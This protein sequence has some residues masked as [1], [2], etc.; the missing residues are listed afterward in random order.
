MKKL[1]NFLLFCL[2]AVVF[3]TNFPL[4]RLGET[5]AMHLEI[6]LPEIWLV[7]FFFTNLANLKSLIKFFP[8]KKLAIISLFPLYASLSII[9]SANRPRAILTA[10]LIW[11]IIFAILNILYL[12][13][14]A[15][16][17]LKQKLTQ[18][19]LATS[20]I[21]SIFCWLQC[22]LDL[23][24]V[25][26]NNSLMCAGCTYS[27]F[28]FPHPNGFAIEPQFMGGLLIAPAIFSFYLAFSKK[29][30]WHYYALAAFFSA[31]LFL[32]F[33]RGAIYAFI[34]GVVIFTTIT[35]MKN[36]RALLTL[37]LVVGAFF[38]TLAAQGIMAAV[39]P[40]SDNF[41]SGVTKSLHHLTLGHLDLRPETETVQ[42]EPTSESTETDSQTDDEAVQEAATEESE[43]IT[44]TYDGYVSESTDVRVNFTN[45]ALEAAVKS[46]ENLIFGTGLG[47]AG[48]ILNCEFPDAVGTPKQ[49]VQNEYASLLLELGLVGIMLILVIFLSF[50]NKLNILICS[51]L[52]SYAVTL[53]FFSGAPNAF[54]IYLFPPLIFNISK[55]F[56]KPRI[57]RPRRKQ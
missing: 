29:S 44:S 20:L 47:S 43:T 14:S 36:R 13:K 16:E 34:I 22:L 15:D 51:I 35:A 18:V 24:G 12:L 42:T 30:S 3:L 21:V 46:P 56:S 4:I 33:S 1:N 49:I 40:T 6:S 48:T 39:S 7:I 57:R 31:T 2:P 23:F 37:P 53:F 19:F 27:A 54:H 11:L 9:W 17:L 8:P 52:V 25:S 45:L 50:Y 28:G 26:A 32:T 10:G 41:I 5:D 38:V 55:N